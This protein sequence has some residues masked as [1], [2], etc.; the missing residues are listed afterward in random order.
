ML[1]RRNRS[2]SRFGFLECLESRVLLSSVHTF[3][4]SSAPWKETLREIADEWIA[5]RRRHALT[6]RA[7]P[8]AIVN[9]HASPNATTPPGNAFTPAQIRQAYGFD[10]VRFGSTQGDG[11]GQ[12]IAIIDAFDDPNIITDLN[13]FDTQFGLPAPPSFT[14]VAQNGSANFPAASGSTNWSIEESL[15]VEWAHAAAPGAK[16]ILVEA[17]DSQYQNL[18]QAAATWAARQPGVSTISMSFGSSEFGSET[19]LDSFF[20]TPAGHPGVT[21]LASTGDS[22]SPTE[23]PAASPNVVA[24]GGTSLSLTSSNAYNSETGWS[25]SGGGIS[26]YEAK[27]TYQDG[28][29][30][31]S[32]T[33]RTNPDISAV[34]DPQTGVAVYDSYDFA[35]SPWIRV[36]GTSLS[37]PLMAGMVAIADQGRATL[38]LTSLDGPSQTL[39]LL[40]QLPAGDF[41]DVLTGSNANA[42]FP[43][44]Y[45]AATGYDLVTGRGSPIVNKL[46]YG[47]MGTSS[48]SGTVFQDNNTNNLKDATDPALS[49]V[50]VYLD[51]NNDGVLE[52]GAT[53]TVSNTSSMLIP[54]ASRLGASSS[55]QISG[56]TDP[57][58]NLSVTL[59]IGHARDSDLTIYLISARR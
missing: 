35:S 30:T 7:N 28:I 55:I 26:N 31:Q 14:K 21:F 15:D 49:G 54:D 47:L 32:D 25:G 46:V 19:G 51:S 13:T 58:S 42:N 1:V 20:T 53:N 3:A 6:N 43:S 38:G 12:T 23:Y 57:I 52:T 22:G 36:G 44:G 8:V 39:P 34:A 17:V 56:T 5:S 59:T 9:G 18:V 2:L 10:Q 16:I 48:V 45:S 40:Y 4:D 50:T 33:A 41:H 37:A 24:V 29:A 27:P 11:T